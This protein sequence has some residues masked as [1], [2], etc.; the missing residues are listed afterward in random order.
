[1]AT[2]KK[3]ILVVDDNTIASRAVKS[4][5]ERLGCEVD[6]ASNGQEA[7][8]LVLNKEYDGISMDIGM[9]VMNGVEACLAIR[10]H[11]AEHH[12]SPVPIIAV[13][14]NNSP[15]EAE[16]YL[17]AGMQAIIDKAFDKEKAEYFLSFCK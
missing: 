7:L 6:L 4:I 17:K 10:Q 12:L 16:E 5:L 2:D 15:A 14:G 1:M 11:E 13:T 8:M 9:P 3:R